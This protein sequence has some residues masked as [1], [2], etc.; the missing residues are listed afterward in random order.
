MSDKELLKRLRS[1]ESFL[2]VK[3][4]DKDRDDWEEH[5]SDGYGFAHQVEEVLEKQRKKRRPRWFH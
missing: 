3:Y 2:G 1:L 4:V 5:L